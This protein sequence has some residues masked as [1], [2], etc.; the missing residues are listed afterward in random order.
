MLLL[1]TSGNRLVTFQQT[2]FPI[3][4]GY[5][6][7]QAGTAASVELLVKHIRPLPDVLT[8]YSAGGVNISQVESLLS[9]EAQDALAATTL[10]G[11][12]KYGPH[13]DSFFTKATEMLSTNMY[14]HF[15]YSPWFYKEPIRLLSDASIVYD[16]ND[17]PITATIGWYAVDER[18]A[19]IAMAAQQ[20]DETDV[21]DAE[22]RAVKQAAHF[23]RDIGASHIQ[24]LVDSE[25][26]ALR[27]DHTRTRSSVQKTDLL[28]D[29]DRAEVVILT[30]GQNRVADGLSRLAR[31]I[32]FEGRADTLPHPG[33]DAEPRC[34]SRNVDGN[35]CQNRVEYPGKSCYLHPR[36]REYC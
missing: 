7:A 23:A 18:N 17:E 14:T 33:R 8:V 27:T 9:V 25:T 34:L 26:V 6:A 21:N 32:Q 22:Y 35:R 4:R 24:V 31:T 11:G 30:G 2:G 36:Y 16:T 29:F 20:V 13:F 5:S 15:H 3:K 10:V 19:I 28:T 1:V 12:N